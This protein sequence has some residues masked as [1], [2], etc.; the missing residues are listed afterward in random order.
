MIKFRDKVGTKTMSFIIGENE[1]Y[2]AC[3]VIVE[4]VDGR[5]ITVQDGDSHYGIM[6]A[7]SRKEAIK[8]GNDFIK[9]MKERE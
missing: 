9:R 4:T 8:K 3:C 7:D 2:T 1:L 6:G 5:K